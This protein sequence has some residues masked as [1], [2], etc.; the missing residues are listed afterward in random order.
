[1]EFALRF[2]VPSSLLT[3]ASEGSTATI[4][5]PAASHVDYTITVDPHEPLQSAFDKLFQS[6]LPHCCLPAQ[7]TQDDA[8]KSSSKG[9]EKQVVRFMAVGQVVYLYPSVSADK[10]RLKSGSVIIVLAVKSKSATGENAGNTSGSNVA[11]AAQVAPGAGAIHAKF[12]DLSLASDVNLQPQSSPSPAPV[13]V[14]AP[15]PLPAPA[16]AAAPSSPPA[17]PSAVGND[18]NSTTTAATAAGTNSGTNGTSGNNSG[19]RS[20]GSSSRQMVHVEHVPLARPHMVHYVDVHLPWSHSLC[21]CCLPR[22]L[23][24]APLVAFRIS[25]L[26]ALRKH[27]QQPVVP[28][29]PPFRLPNKP[30]PPI[31]AY[32]ATVPLSAPPRRFPGY[33][34]SAAAPSV[35]QQYRW[36]ADAAPVVAAEGMMLEWLAEPRVGLLLDL[37]EIRRQLAEIMQINELAAARRAA[38]AARGAAAAAASPAPAATADPYPPLLWWCCWQCSRCWTLYRRAVSIAAFTVLVAKFPRFVMLWRAHLRSPEVVFSMMAFQFGAGRQ[39]QG[40]C[41]AS[42]LLQV[43]GVKGKEQLETGFA[44]HLLPLLPGGRG[45]HGQAGEG[46]ESR[47][48]VGGRGE[49]WREGLRGVEWEEY[50]RRVG[51]IAAQ[52]GLAGEQYRCCCSQCC[53]GEGAEGRVSEGAL[54]T[55]PGSSSGMVISGA[56][57][58]DFALK[59]GTLFCQPLFARSA[60]LIFSDCA[61]SRHK[62]RVEDAAVEEARNRLAAGEGS[63]VQDRGKQ[64]VDSD[65]RATA[66][67]AAAAA[68]AAG[69]GSAGSSGLVPVNSNMVVALFTYRVTC[70]LRWVRLYGSRVNPAEACTCS[71]QKNPGPSLPHPIHDLPNLMIRFGAMP[72]PAAA[73]GLEGSATTVWKEFPEGNRAAVAK[74]EKDP[75]EFT[76]IKTFQVG[77]FHGGSELDKEEMQKEYNVR[78]INLPQ[79]GASSS[80]TSTLEDNTSGPFF[81]TLSHRVEEFL[82]RFAPARLAR[83]GRNGPLARAIT[84]WAGQLDLEDR[85]WAAIA[86]GPYSFG[87]IKPILRSTIQVE[88]FIEMIAGSM[89]PAPACTRCRHCIRRY[90][91]AVTLSSLVATF[92][93][94]PSSA[95]LRCILSLFPPRSARFR[96]FLGT[97]GV[98]PIPAAVPDSLVAALLEGVIEEHRLQ[99]LFFGI[100]LI[101]EEG[102]VGNILEPVGQDG[103]G[104]EGGLGWQGVRE[105]DEE[106]RMWE[107]VDS[108]R[109]AAIMAWP[110]VEGRGEAGVDG[111]EGMEECCAGMERAQG[112]GRPY[113]PQA[114]VDALAAAHVAAAGAAGAAAPHSASHAAATPG[115]GGRSGGA[116]GRSGKAGPR[117]CASPRCSKVE[118]AG[119]QL[120]LSSRCGKAAY[121]SRECQK[122]HWPS[123]KLTCQPKAKGGGESS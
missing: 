16:P 89:S 34:S 106:W 105:G 103:V 76:G 8:E 98:A 109:R 55:Q 51:E 9:E 92:A 116:E 2:R 5:Q 96:K 10:A 32:S 42:L 104:Q 62:E 84:S 81:T 30:T 15:A 44:A 75:G 101:G 1:M 7:Q 87:K 61:G 38:S 54:G 24:P 28:S 60:A 53:Q 58:S 29:M 49:E 93:Y 107:E 112:R 80:S 52:G 48:S 21:A 47:G 72:K 14:P 12:E 95:L 63:G 86:L 108:W 35:A 73:P 22:M 37:Q 97:L 27:L 78:E 88:I 67:A 46:G 57:P 119:V 26:A 65:A 66:P 68:A 74:I 121:C 85:T 4:Q 50:V 33:T 120:K 110:A 6:H 71:D 79:P 100:R 23:R 102:E 25:S 19:P 20:S 64:K 115:E 3:H 36:K 56:D 39:A 69:S 59:C 18:T 13:S 113:C 94:R 70:L 43:L 99:F 45:A 82:R 114:H 91:R 41:L 111:G 118:G 123:H 83:E 40:D 31:L 77:A 122:A 90:D 117:G 11:T 17:P